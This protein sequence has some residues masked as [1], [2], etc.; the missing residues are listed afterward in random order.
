LVSKIVKNATILFVSS[1]VFYKKT[2]HM[3]ERVQADLEL[4]LTELEQMQR[5]GLLSPEETKLV[6]KKRKKYEYKLQKQSK[7]KEDILCYIQYESGL[8]DLIEMRRDKIGYLHKKNEIDGSIAKRINQLFRIVEHRFGQTDAKLW[9]S[10]LAFLKRMDWKAEA[11]KILE[12]FTQALCHKEE[13]WIFAARFQMENQNSINIARTTLL[14]GLR[15]HKDSIKIYREYFMLEMEFLKKLVEKPELAEEFEDGKTEILEGKIVQTVFLEAIENVNEPIFAAELLGLALK[16]GIPKLFDNL[17]TA[18]L[19][20]YG[21]QSWSWLILINLELYPKPNEDRTTSQKMSNFSTEVQKG[22]DSM[23]TQ[24]FLA[25][26]L[27]L[28]QEISENHTHLQNF[29]EETV[30]QVLNTGK[31]LDILTEE[32]TQVL[33]NFE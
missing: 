21:D 3:A 11:G 9:I 24:D 17:K 6:I 20:K 23:K 29:C 7:V 30:F 28:L 16:S 18:L 25:E 33:S 26:I 8:L 12:R 22:L 19:E 2:I 31:N 14:K 15:F 32:Q 13:V 10:H 1:L 4:M 5:V 27:K